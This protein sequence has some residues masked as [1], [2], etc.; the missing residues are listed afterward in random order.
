M[1][2]RRLQK[3]LMDNNWALRSGSMESTH[4]INFTSTSQ[5][6]RSAALNSTFTA[7]RSSP[8]L[9]TRAE[10]SAFKLLPKNLCN[11]LIIG[12]SRSF[13]NRSNTRWNVLEFS[14]GAGVVDDGAASIGANCNRVTNLDTID[15]CSSS[16][17][18]ISARSSTPTSPRE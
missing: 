4:S 10:S 14:E 1:L 18:S 5:D 9:S 7:L 6:L 11:P 15:F 2:S 13:V 8:I 12:F 3:Y 16:D 17:I